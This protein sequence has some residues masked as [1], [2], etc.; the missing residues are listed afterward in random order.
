MMKISSAEKKMTLLVSLLLEMSAIDASKVIK[1]LVKSN[2]SPKFVRKYIQKHFEKFSGTS[3]LDKTDIEEIVSAYKQIMNPTKK[4]TSNKKRR[5]KRS[6]SSPKP[7][8]KP[9]PKLSDPAPEPIPQ[10]VHEP[11]SQPAH[12]SNS[13]IRSLG[14]AMLFFTILWGTTLVLSLPQVPE[15]DQ[16]ITPVISTTP[17]LP[18]SIFST[19]EPTPGPKQSPPLPPLPEPKKPKKPSPFP[20]VPFVEENK[21]GFT[22]YGFPKTEQKPKE[23]IFEHFRKH[24]IFY[25]TS[26]TSFSISS[27]SSLYI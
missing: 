21:E 19:P 16:P 26:L 5:S 24:S 20:L 6:R 2:K 7:S 13:G 22:F 1:S 14:C 18:P 11:I 4:K 17:I 9:S 12:E 10:P 3:N 8:T 15:I 27:L 23:G 25:I